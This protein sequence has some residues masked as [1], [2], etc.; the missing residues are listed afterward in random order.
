MPLDLGSLTMYMGVRPTA[1]IG[2][3]D[4]PYKPDS[5]R[6]IRC[7]VLGQERPLRESK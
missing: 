3:Y 6:F 4:R 1:N 5:S 2:D 7:T